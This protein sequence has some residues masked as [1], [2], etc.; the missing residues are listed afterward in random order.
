MTGSPIT[1]GLLML[2]I[3][4]AVAACSPA[5]PL[6]TPATPTTAAAPTTAPAPTPAAVARAPVVQQ[7]LPNVRGKSF[8]SAIVTFPPGSHAVSHRH[9]DASVYAYVLEGTVLSRLDGEPI[10]RYGQ[11]ENWTEQPGA[12]HVATENASPTAPARLLVVFIADTG[13]QLKIDDPPS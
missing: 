10:R 6:A 8:T 1:T 9:G 7:E 4:G 5:T 12:H 3:A 2:G 13:A 11:G